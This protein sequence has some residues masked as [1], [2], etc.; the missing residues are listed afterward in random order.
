MIIDTIRSHVL[1]PF[2][3]GRI[4][5]FKKIIMM[6]FEFLKKC[7]GSQVDINTQKEIESTVEENRTEPSIRMINPS[8]P[9]Y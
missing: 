8:N 6:L 5:R 2:Q 3:V 4:K 9:I 7:V 1:Y